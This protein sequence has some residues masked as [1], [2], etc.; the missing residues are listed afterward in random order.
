VCTVCV[1]IALAVLAIL[2]LRKGIEDRTL[3]APPPYHDSHISVP[4]IA[5][6]QYNENDSQF[7]PHPFSATTSSL[8][9]AANEPPAY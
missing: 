2:K 8:P 4:P 9:A 7:S 6:A 5:A 3:S 1:Q